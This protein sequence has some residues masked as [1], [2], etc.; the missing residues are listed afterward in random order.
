MNREGVKQEQEGGSWD[1]EGR[2]R[3]INKDRTHGERGDVWSGFVP[4]TSD[5]SL[6]LRWQ[7]CLPQLQAAV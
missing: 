3:E 7:T 4:A 2:G 1:E 6:R 5:P